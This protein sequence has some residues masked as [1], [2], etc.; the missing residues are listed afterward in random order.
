MPV[1]KCGKILSPEFQITIFNHPE[2]AVN[3]ALYLDEAIT[4]GVQERLIC[5]RLVNALI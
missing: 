4:L 3:L 5:Q 2:W 1:V